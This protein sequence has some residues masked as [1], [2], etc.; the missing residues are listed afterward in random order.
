MTRWR[1]NFQ[2]VYGLYGLSVTT[3]RPFVGVL[4][5]LSRRFDESQDCSQARNTHTQRNKIINKK[6][7]VNILLILALF[8]SNSKYIDF[9][10]NF[11]LV[12][13]LMIFLYKTIRVG[14]L[15]RITNGHVIIKTIC[16]QIKHL[17]LGASTVSSLTEL[18]KLHL[19][20]FFHWKNK[21]WLDNIELEF[22]IFFRRM[23]ICDKKRSKKQILVDIYWR[24]WYCKML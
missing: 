4:R 22:S 21:L 20:F 10:F 5:V 19:C 3:N 6:K 1:H 9:Y 15:V 12:S 23:F 14:S 2:S 16:F 24:S 13:S 11:S 7:I 18:C 8:H 17:L